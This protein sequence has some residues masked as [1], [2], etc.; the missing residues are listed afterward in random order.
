[1]VDPCTLMYCGQNFGPVGILMYTLYKS[2]YEI[3]RT[4]KL[5]VIHLARVTLSKFVEVETGSTFIPQ[6]VGLYLVQFRR[7]IVPFY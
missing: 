6:Q 3:I 4:L 1:M 2:M 7:E 5:I